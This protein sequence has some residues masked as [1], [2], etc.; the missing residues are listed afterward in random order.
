MNSDDKYITNIREK[1]SEVETAHKA[2]L[3][4][5]EKILLS[6]DGPIVTILDVLYGEVKLFV[7]EQHTISADKKIS[8]L[9][10]I[11]EGEEVEY[12]EVIVHKRGRPLVH[13]TSY[14]PKARCSDRVIGEL[15]EE[16]KTTGKIL[17]THEI[18]TTRKIKDIS[19][20]KPT[21]LLS[22]LFNTSEN[23]LT[24]EYILKHKKEIVLWTKE[25][26]PINSF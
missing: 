22:D 21:A 14:I 7:L 8:E 9:L 15:L 12:R 25:T 23:M 17:L 3:S 2:K 4:T 10:E 18:E 1:I 11:E 16:E 24:R 6:I 5:V 20:E 26:Y 13:S 19:I